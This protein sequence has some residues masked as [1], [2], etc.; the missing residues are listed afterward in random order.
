MSMGQHT[1]ID[2]IIYKVNTHTRQLNTTKA[3]TRA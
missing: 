2:T 1:N 3:N